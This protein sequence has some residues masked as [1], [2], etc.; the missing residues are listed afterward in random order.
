MIAR[1]KTDVTPP[2]PRLMPVGYSAPSIQ[3]R[4]TRPLHSRRAAI[5]ANAEAAFKG[6]LNDEKK[7][8]NAESNNSPID[9]ETHVAIGAGRK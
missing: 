5:L 9:D 4:F 2:L 1:P 7:R 3:R 6:K 8:L